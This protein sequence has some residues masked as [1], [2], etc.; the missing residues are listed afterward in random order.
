MS[1]SLF[2]KTAA[3]A[4]GELP[5]AADELAARRAIVA[6]VAASALL[7]VDASE[8][9]MSAIQAWARRRGGVRPV[10]AGTITAAE[11]VASCEPPEV[12]VVDL[13]FESGRG[14]AVAS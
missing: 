14:I 1:T 2:D 9:R 4:P 10:F 8:A 7:V 6:E 3:V 11:E 13:L 5:A 12:A